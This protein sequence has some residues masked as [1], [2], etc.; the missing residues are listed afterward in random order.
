MV[1]NLI[2]IQP[3]ALQPSDQNSFVFVFLRLTFASACH[4]S[5]SAPRSPVKINIKKSNRDV[6]VMRDK[7]IKNE[8]PIYGDAFIQAK[9]DG[10]SA[11][12][13]FC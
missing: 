8:L 10:I 1:L 13:H 3:L 7:V 2:N 6:G 5:L 9:L 11:T 12:K 4:Q